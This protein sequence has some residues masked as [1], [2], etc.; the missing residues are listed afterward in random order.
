MIFGNSWIISSIV[1]LSYSYNSQLGT[2]CNFYHP[3]TN[4]I[5]S[6]DAMTSEKYFCFNFCHQ[7]IIF[8]RKWVKDMNFWIQTQF[9]CLILPT[10]WVLW[11]SL[12]WILARLETNCKSS[13]RVTFILI[14]LVTKP[15]VNLVKLWVNSRVWNHF[16]RSTED[17]HQ[18]WQLEQWWSHQLWFKS[19]PVQTAIKIKLQTSSSC[20]YMFQLL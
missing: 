3:L 14:G 1:F 19:W 11:R 8:R 17:I 2:S 9:Q 6:Q 13:D 18:F 4:R 7:L 12:S 15:K 5:S 16:D 20:W 10:T